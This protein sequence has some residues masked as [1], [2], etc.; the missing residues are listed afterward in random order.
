MYVLINNSRTAWPAEILSSVLSFAD[1]LLKDPFTLFIK[2]MLMKRYRTN[3]LVLVQF[4]LKKR[5]IFL[6][7]L[8]V[9]NI[10]TFCAVSNTLLNIIS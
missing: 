6:K 2:I 3:S 7:I 10:K 9:K 1:N 5:L 8:E 4:P